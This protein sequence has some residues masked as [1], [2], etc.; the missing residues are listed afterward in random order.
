M[1]FQKNRLC[2]YSFLCRTSM[3]KDNIINSMPK[4]IMWNCRKLFQNAVSLSLKSF[5]K[6]VLEI[7][8]SNT[9]FA[10]K[11]V[12]PMYCSCRIKTWKNKNICQFS[13]YSRKRL[14]HYTYRNMVKW[15]LRT[16]PLISTN[17]LVWKFCG[18]AQFP[19]SFGWFSRNYAETVP[20]HKI[21]IP[22]N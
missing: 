19:H 18:K 20:F 10:R 5:F 2:S 14:S 1:P 7:V 6:R 13:F 4:I 3:V 9:Y 21:S 11:N 17:F 15:S 16:I 8:K 22:G 12:R